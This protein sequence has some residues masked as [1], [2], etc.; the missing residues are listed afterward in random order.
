MIDTVY[1]KYWTENIELREV[2]G[3]LYV[4][5]VKDNEPVVKSEPADKN[6]IT[7]E[8]AGST[9]PV[10][11]IKEDGRVLVNGELIDDN[12]AIYSAML[13]FLE[14]GGFLEGWQRGGF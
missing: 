14:G 3:I 1:K 4:K 5:D 11:L 8:I 13:D 10:I 2:P 12:K 7:F 6:A 9:I